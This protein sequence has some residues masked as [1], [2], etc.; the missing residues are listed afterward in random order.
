[1][2]LSPN[3]RQMGDRKL[4]TA[5][6][7]F[8]HKGV[9]FHNQDLF[10]RQLLETGLSSIAGRLAVASDAMLSTYDEPKKQ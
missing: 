4:S 8:A 1:M 7:K 9:I 5:R 10:V 2:L 3:Q 6:L